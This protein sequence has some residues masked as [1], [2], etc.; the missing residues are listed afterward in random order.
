[1]RLE[2]S[3][4]PQRCPLIDEKR[5]VCNTLDTFRTVL[6][7]QAWKDCCF[8][9]GDYR[10]REA[11]HREWIPYPKSSRAFTW[12]RKT[13]GALDRFRAKLDSFA[14]KQLGAEFDPTMY[15]CGGLLTASS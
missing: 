13:I 8:D 15:F 3:A 5:K 2:D 12:H 10:K 11:A 9:F 4:C 6:Y 1:M 14:C 7:S